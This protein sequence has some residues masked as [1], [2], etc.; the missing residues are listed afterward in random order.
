M[1]VTLFFVPMICEPLTSHPLVDCRET[2]FHL[3]GLELADD[4]GD[5]QSLRVDILIGSDHYWDLIT[6]RLQRGADGPVVIKM[7]LGWVLSGP[8]AVSGQMDE[9]HNL[10]V[11]T[12]HIGAPTPEMQTLD[13]TMKSFW[14]LESFGIPST[15]RSLYDELQD[16]IVFHDGRYEV[17]LPWKTPKRDLPNNYDLSLKRLNGLLRRLKHEP[18]VLAEY[19]TVIKTQLHQ[20][21]VEPVEDQSSVDVPGV[22]YLPHHA[23]IRRDKA[24]TK[25]HVVHF[26]EGRI[27]LFR[28]EI[29]LQ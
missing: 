14:E 24:T 11:H 21:I 3:T 5:N 1:I 26:A 13:D 12:L 7:K 18:D 29:S 6:G 10:V 28:A 8:V 4:P 23:V 27:K 2:S 25:L 9:L 20:G 22:R 15:D 19:D 17:Q 16:T